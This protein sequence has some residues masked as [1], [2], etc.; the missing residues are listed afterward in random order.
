[1]LGKL[2]LR[3]AKRQL[4]DYVLYFITISCAVACMY[5]YNA[6]IFS[7]QVKRL[8]RLE[9]LPLMVIATSLLIILVLGWLVSYMTGYMLRKR[10]RELSIYMVS[11][12]S[13]R[14]IAGLFL[15]ENLMIAG[16]AFVFGLLAGILL[17]R[18]V[19]AAVLRM[20][21]MTFTLGFSVSFQTA[22]VTLLYF[23][24]MYL[25]ALHK[26]KRRLR[27]IRLYDLLYYDRQNE[28]RLR[29]MSVVLGILS[30]LFMLAVFFFGT[31]AAARIF[32]DRSV[33][34]NVFDIMILHPGGMMDF[35]AYEKRIGES[36][37]IQKSCSYGIYGWES[38]EFF[39]LRRQ[40]AQELEKP[41][42][43]YICGISV[44]YVYETERLSLSETDAG[45]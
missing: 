29:S 1:M 22:G 13:N 6:L 9:I 21:G 19:E 25:F 11:G 33:E 31:G 28:G 12:L 34:L 8:P 14:T 44:G 27:K 40:A 2:V 4:G 18:L 30:V 41:A 37:P 5:A 20:F 7:E 43:A 24:G 32:A 45:I 42:T 17:S 38:R 15:Y 10:S 3:N 35:S 36:F 39:S 16:M 26:N 23:D